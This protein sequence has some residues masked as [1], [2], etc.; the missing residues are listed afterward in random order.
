MTPPDVRRELD[1]YTI[2]EVL[3]DISGSEPGLVLAGTGS[4]LAY[5]GAAMLERLGLKPDGMAEVTATIDKATEIT[6]R[7]PEEKPS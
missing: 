3:A 1:D 2:G 5:I 4:L 6:I 7:W